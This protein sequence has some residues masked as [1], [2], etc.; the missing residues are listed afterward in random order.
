MLQ[1]KLLLLH[2]LGI[3]L[4]SLSL[5][6]CHTQRDISQG[7]VKT[8]LDTDI[9]PDADDAGAVAVLHALADRGEVEILAMNCN[10][11]CD[12][13][14]P[15]LDAFN[16]YYGRGDIPVGTLKGEGS[17]GDAP[18]WSGLTYNRYI[19]QNFPNDLKNGSQAPD[20][21]AV[22]RKVLATQADTSVTIISIGALTNLRNLLQSGSDQVS[23]LKG[24][25]LVK[26]KVKMLSLMAGTYPTGKK[27]DPNF[28]MDI[29]ASMQVVD[30]WPTPIMFSGTEV[31]APIKTG[32]KLLDIKDHK[33]PIRE[34]YLQWDAHFYSLW[35]TTYHGG[36]IHPHDSYDQTSVIYAVRGCKDYWKAQMNGSNMVQPDGSNEWKQTPTEIIIF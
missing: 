5:C 23:P 29:E 8:I 19:A 11:T 14:A 22:Y 6:S 9:G 13:G 31:G 16:T 26:K 12:W 34:A 10:T 27:N 35:D 15:C 1:I 25:E 32:V 18:E 4:V 2:F 3:F 7:V 33:N 20:A 28:S 24:I 30:Q 21:V 36:S 17:S